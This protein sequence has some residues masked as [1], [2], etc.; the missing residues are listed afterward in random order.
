METYTKQTFWCF[1]L[2]LQQN[3]VFEICT[4]VVPLILCNYEAW[5]R[6]LRKG[7]ELYLK[8]IWTKKRRILVA[9]LQLIEA[10]SFLLLFCIVLKHLQI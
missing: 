6:M 9:P 5:F 7:H 10:S 4:R 1:P 8:N 3:V 2:P